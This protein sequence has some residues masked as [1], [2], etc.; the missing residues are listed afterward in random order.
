MLSLSL[1][2][3]V[4]PLPSACPHLQH[5]RLHS[6][7]L[8]AAGESDTGDTGGISD[9]HNVNSVSQIPGYSCPSTSSNFDTSKMGESDNDKLIK[10]RD[11]CQLFRIEQSEDK[12]RYLV[13]TRDIKPLE[14]II[15]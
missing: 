4:S 13:A 10:A 14:L 12:G 5:C 15:R 8:S 7:E 3:P 2:L 1:I 9:R 6:D 11:T